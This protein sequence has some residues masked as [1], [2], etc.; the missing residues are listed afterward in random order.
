M[1]AIRLPFDVAGAAQHSLVI[2]DLQKTAGRDLGSV[3]RE[4]DRQITVAGLGYG[5]GEMIENALAEALPIGQPVGR[6]QIDAGLPHC[7][8]AAASSHRAETRFM[9]APAEKSPQTKPG[10]I[11]EASRAPQFAG[12]AVALTRDGAYET[13][14]SPFPFPAR[15]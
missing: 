3:Q 6:S 5:Q 13:A 2:A 4:R 14:R 8:A 11:P 12:Y 9:I 1:D 15:S 10:I 7:A